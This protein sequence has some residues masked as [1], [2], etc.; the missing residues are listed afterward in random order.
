[1]SKRG[2]SIAT[3][4]TALLAGAGMTLALTACT[5]TTEPQE[6]QPQT[7]NDPGTVAMFVPSDGLTLSQHTPLNKWAKL[8][9]RISDALK[10]AGIAADDIDVSTADSLDKQSQDIQDYVVEHA[11]NATAKDADNDA[12]TATTVRDTTLVIA[13]VTESDAATRQYGDYVSQRIE[14]TM[15]DGD[16]AD[17]AQNNANDA[18]ASS[19]GHDGADDADEAESDK[20]DKTE[21]QDDDDADQTRHEAIERLRSAL[22]LAKENG[23]HVVLLANEVEG[24]SPDAFV[25]MSTA[26][27]IGKVQAEKLIGKLQLSKASKDNPKSIE[28][29]LPYD[30]EAE[31]TTF[32]AEAFAGAWSVLEPYFKEGKATSP[33][34]A[35]SSDTTAEDWRT[36][37]FDAR[38]TA[39]VKAVL[40]GRLGYS[41]GQKKL[42]KLDGV[43]AMND[44]IAAGVVEALDDM[45]YS[46]SAADINPSI[47]ISGIV[48]NITGRRDLKRSQVPDPSKAPDP[49]QQETGDDA[50]DEARWP[51]VTGYG[52]YLDEVPS[53]VNGKQWMTGMEN[54]DVL[55]AD[56]A[57]VC[58]KL[59]QGASLSS[60]SYVTRTKV[61]GKQTP[62]VSEDLLAVSAS[63]LKTA[64]IDP[65]Y[66]TPADAGL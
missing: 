8:T 42:T 50:D 47:T 45:G 2:I 36:V 35:L 61:E 54:R 58:V 27:L 9:P 44:F 63:N 11:T 4:L 39:Q 60:L 10:K 20:S 7:A 22:R 3:K 6:P 18:A 12:K 65:G 40:E 14:D 43:I 23:M 38:K 34:G 25:R 26:T 24:V 15:D 33:S 16:S 64:L 29:M 62:T 31:D 41:K 1:M 17:E 32:A 52:A 13:P 48:G 56:I 59:N 46:G 37:A 51:I 66:I 57:E 49:T 53:V 19:D 55:A 21:D 5:Q 30:S 28:I